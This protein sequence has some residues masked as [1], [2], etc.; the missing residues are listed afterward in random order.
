MRHL[1]IDYGTKRIG[2]AVSDATGT[3]AFPKTVLPNDAQLLEAIGELIE[4]YQVAVIVIGRSLDRMAVPNTVQVAIDE[5]VTDLTLQFGLPVHFELEHYTTQAATRIQ[6]RT[7][8]TDASAAA[9]ILD[10][11]LKNQK[12]L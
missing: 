8:K 7:E 6:G 3:M 12:S 1:G 2:I 5:F 10:G 4:T 11:Y 9:L